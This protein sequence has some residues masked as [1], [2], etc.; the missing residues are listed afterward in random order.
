LLQGHAG[1]RRVAT[2]TASHDANPLRVDDLLFGKLGDPI[3]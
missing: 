1:Q 3:R 2:V